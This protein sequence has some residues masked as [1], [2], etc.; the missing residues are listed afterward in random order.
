MSLLVDH[1]ALLALPIVALTVLLAWLTRGTRPP[2]RRCI[3]CG[4]TDL[5][6]CPGGCSWARLGPDV[7]TTCD[8]DDEQLADQLFRTAA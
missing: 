6:A 5:R 4:C 7:C 2:V 1:P 3:G 8:L